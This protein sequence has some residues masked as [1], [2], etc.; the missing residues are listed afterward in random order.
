M[1][2]DAAGAIKLLPDSRGRIA[3]PGTRRLGHVLRHHPP[4]LVD[5][6]AGCLVWDPAQRLT[7]AAALQH[8]WLMHGSAAPPQPPPA[9]AMPLHTSAQG[10]G[11]GATQA[12][13]ANGGGTSDLVDFPPFV[14]TG[15]GADSSALQAVQLAA[16]HWQRHTTKQTGQAAE[17]GGKGA[18]RAIWQPAAQQVAPPDA[19]GNQAGPQLRPPPAPVLQQ[20]AALTQEGRNALRDSGNMPMAARAADSSKSA[21]KDSSAGA[22]PFCALHSACTHGCLIAWSVWVSQLARNA[23]VLAAIELA[24]ASLLRVLA[25]MLAQMSERF[26]QKPVFHSVQ[27]L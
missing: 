19:S 27:Y 20:S 1:Q 9:A 16:Q 8:P 22:P 2:L 15:D 11:G 10:L 14:N 12:P 7:P 4:A 24:S 3:R 17:A 5:L 13:A 18:S 26:V 21:A 6:V 23:M 25:S